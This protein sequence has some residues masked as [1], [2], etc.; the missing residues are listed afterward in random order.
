MFA[1]VNCTGL[2]ELALPRI[3]TIGIG[4]FSGCSNIW[5]V[6]FGRG[7]TEAQIITL[8]EKIFGAPA[9]RAGGEMFATN[10][11]TID[12]ELGEFVLPKPV[13][14]SWNGISWKS[15]TVLPAFSNI[16]EITDSELIVYPNPASDRFHIA[17]IIANTPVTVL[18]MTGK[19]VLQKI[20][21][22]GEAIS[23][24]NL[25]AGVYFLR[26]K[27]KTVKVVKS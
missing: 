15:V 5:K 18:D 26:V 13:G 4:A 9:A 6:S 16:N 12:L 24:E 27:G 20:V 25:P 17:G 8:S 2:R 11:A 1:F 21:N 10:P 22:P 7:H 14:N 19:T 3:K 23:V